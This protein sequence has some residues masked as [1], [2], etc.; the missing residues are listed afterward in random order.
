MGTYGLLQDLE[1]FSTPLRGVEITVPQS[2]RMRTEDQKKKKKKRKQ[3]NFPP[4]RAARMTAWRF[5]S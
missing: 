4:K 5:W 1:L 2:I 3:T